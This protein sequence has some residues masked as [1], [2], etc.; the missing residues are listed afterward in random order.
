ML[1]FSVEL[2]HS[3]TG[4]DL[5]LC[6]RNDLGYPRKLAFASLYALRGELERV[7]I[8]RPA[9]EHSNAWEALAQAARFA[10]GLG[11]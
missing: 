11:L 7:L 2:S 5:V 8:G 3:R 10:H 6:T 9:K 4:T 1:H